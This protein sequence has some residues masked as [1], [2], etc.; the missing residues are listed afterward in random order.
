MDSLTDGTANLI[1]YDMTTVD[2][3]ST[4]SVW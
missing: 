4:C 2:D 3:T 1:T